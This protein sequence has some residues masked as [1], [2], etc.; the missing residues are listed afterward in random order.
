VRSWRPA[1]AGQ[2]VAWGATALG[3]IAYALLA[4]RAAS[5]PRPGLFEAC[6]FILPLMAFALAVAWRSQRRV[7][8]LS[9]WLVAAVAMFLARDQ[10]AGGTHWVLLAQH[11][12]INMAL[13]LGFGRTL[14]PGAKPLVSR[15]AELVHGS[16]SP[17]LVGYT[18]SVTWA[19]TAFFAL[20]A[21]ASVLLFALAPAAVWSAFV[22][23][24]SLPL[25]GAMFAG[26]YLVRI[27]RI[28][29]AERSGF[30]QAVAAYR[31]LS[32]GR[33]ARPD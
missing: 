10:L 18:R 25:L 8:W 12:G 26:E 7:A 22:N 21:L 15:L 13:C 16:L 27:A 1:Q 32:S 5:T 23:L 9:L 33:K 20:T 14:A 29:R 4:H 30:L 2:A 3:C 6:V 11:V 19:W 24:L 28:P 31:Q 17:R